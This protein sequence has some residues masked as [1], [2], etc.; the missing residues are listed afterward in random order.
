M[1]RPCPNRF[2]H[3]YA[4]ALL[5]GK[6]SPF[7]VLEGVR[8]TSLLKTYARVAEACTTLNQLRGFQANLE[9]LLTP[10]ERQF[11]IRWLLKRSSVVERVSAQ[12]LSSSVS[13]LHRPSR[14]VL[15]DSMRAQGVSWA[16]VLRA[17][18]KLASSRSVAGFRRLENTR[19]WALYRAETEKSR[20]LLICWQGSAGRLMTTMP[21]FLQALPS[22]TDVLLL[23]Y[24]RPG[25]Y[26]NGLP[27]LGGNLA[28]AAC[29]LR[30]K[31]GRLQYEKVITLGSSAGTGPALLAS[32]ETRSERT[33][34]HGPFDPTS[35]EISSSWDA[36][37]ARWKY[38]LETGSQLPRI[39]YLVG[40]DCT[41]DI[42]NAQKLQAALGGEVH[43]VPGAGHNVVE[44]LLQTGRLAQWLRFAIY[45]DSNS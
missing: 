23:K 28:E 26:L 16:L 5:P 44:P 3:R 40:A 2:C 29:G 42:A 10:I 31:V 41:G 12:F 17:R 13:W 38:S 9:S 6:V 19:G 34:L 33:I 45:S 32:L 24:V 43:E 36:F 35:S 11:F 15:N 27:G 20:V 8:L 18:Q 1:S 14:S 7:R 21:D 39:F 37:L 4:M 30:E 22:G 25:G